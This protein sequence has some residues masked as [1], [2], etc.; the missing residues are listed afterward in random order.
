MNIAEILKDCPK[1]TKLYSPAYGDVYLLH[2]MSTN[3]SIIVRP[4][5]NNDFNV[6]FDSDGRLNVN[7]NGECILF[8]SKENRDWS[9]FKAPKK[10]KEYDFK[11]FD[12]VLVRNDV[13]HNWSCNLFSY[14]LNNTSFP[15]MCVGAA[16][17]QCIPFEGN[18]HL[19]GTSNPA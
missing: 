15:Y 3:H 17:R 5:S 8:P 18:E 10:E 16:Y 13:T 9:T 7:C 19:V 11:P 2:I 1:G 6:S 4:D 12:R 14:K